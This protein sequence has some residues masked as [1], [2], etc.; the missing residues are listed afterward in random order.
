MTRLALD[1]SQA[2]NAET[3]G[4]LCD[5][6]VKHF[7]AAV[8]DKVSAAIDDATMSDM[9]NQVDGGKAEPRSVARAF[10]RAHKLDK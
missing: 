8:L 6:A 10:V 9:N 2:A 5:D 1:P 7:A 3:F 4:R